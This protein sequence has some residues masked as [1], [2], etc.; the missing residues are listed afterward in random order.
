MSP[1]EKRMQMIKAEDRNKVRI[2]ELPTGRMVWSGICPGSPS[3][4]ENERLRRFNEWWSVR[5]KLRIDR[6]Y[7]RD[8]MWWDDQ[9]RGY[10]W[11]YAITEPQDDTGGFGVMDFPGGLYAVANFADD[12][13]DV[14]T[15]Y[16]MMRKWIESSGCFDVDPDRHVLN[17][18]IG[19][20]QAAKAMGY[21]QQDLYVP[22]KV[23]QA[24]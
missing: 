7:G 22:I 16:D 20:P 13:G 6:F 12:G 14:G 15:I 4:S 23:V 9:E 19:T 10:A 2:I 3:T 8:F 18:S 1:G 5:D 17:Q 11:G 24:E 21:C